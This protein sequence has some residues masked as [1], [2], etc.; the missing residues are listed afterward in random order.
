MTRV[1]CTAKGFTLLHFAWRIFRCLLNLK[2]VSI[3]PHRSQSL[4][5]YHTQKVTHLVFSSFSSR[6]LANNQTLAGVEQPSRKDHWH[7]KIRPYSQLVGGFQLVKVT[8]T[9]KPSHRRPA[10]GSR[11]FSQPL[12]YE[13]IS[14]GLEIHNTV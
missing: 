14:P 7:Q 2:F 1:F 4:K 12:R 13:F 9:S 8:R 10:L 11:I 3:K 5:K 6:Q